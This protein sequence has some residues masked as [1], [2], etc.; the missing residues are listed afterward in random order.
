MDPPLGGAIAMSHNEFTRLCHKF[1]FEGFARDK[2]CW[3][4]YF[5]VTG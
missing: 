1:S 4:T 5:Q 3:R 2:Y